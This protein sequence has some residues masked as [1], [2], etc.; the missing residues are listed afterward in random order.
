MVTA[1]SAETFQQFVGSLPLADRETITESYVHYQ[2]AEQ[3][4]QSQVPGFAI[5]KKGVGL[6]SKEALGRLRGRNAQ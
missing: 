3:A 4:W 2:T 5:G 6:L 1:G